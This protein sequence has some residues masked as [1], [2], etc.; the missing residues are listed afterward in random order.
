MPI[1]E[2]NLKGFIVATRTVCLL[3]GDNVKSMLHSVRS[4]HTRISHHHEKI[5]L[6]FYFLCEGGESLKLYKVFVRQ[7]NKK[8]L[9]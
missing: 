2:R 1:E 4:A 8:K 7:Q 3:V 6:T 5:F 9:V